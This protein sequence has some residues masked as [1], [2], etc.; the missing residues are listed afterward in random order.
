MKSKTR[1]L[2]WKQLAKMQSVVF[3]IR[4]KNKKVLD[5]L[6]EMRYNK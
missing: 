5:S 4:K 6:K 2:E 1:F 3:Q